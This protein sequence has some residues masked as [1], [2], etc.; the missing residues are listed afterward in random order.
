MPE[1]ADI[2]PRTPGLPGVFGKFQWVKTQDFGEPPDPRRTPHPHAVD[3]APLARMIGVALHLIDGD[4]GDAMTAV[5]A[6]D[7]D[8][9]IHL[10]HLAAACESASREAGGAWPRQEDLPTAAVSGSALPGL[11]TALR[12]GGLAAAT[13]VARAMDHDL[14]LR[15][16]DSL[17]YYWQVPVL[18]LTMAVND[19]SLG[20]PRP[21]G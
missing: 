21:A 17:L 6:D 14:R 15:V 18:A 10:V 8:G 5:A 2:W 9:P 7:R 1:P 13:A 20:L 16:L 12:Q 4:L 3:P 11:M 19:G